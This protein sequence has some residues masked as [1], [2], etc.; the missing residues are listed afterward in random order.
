M[1]ETQQNHPGNGTWP[2][3]P[4][5][6]NAI[7]QLMAWIVELL[8]DRVLDEVVL[9]AFTK[10]TQTTPRREIDLALKGLDQ[11]EDQ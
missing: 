2:A 4:Y 11:V 8:D 7:L 3:P 5:C 6:K 1:Y 10:K 9:R